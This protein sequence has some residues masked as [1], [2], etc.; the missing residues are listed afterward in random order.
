MKKLLAYICMITIL[1]STVVNA[2]EISY[3]DNTY[4][5]ETVNK[6][7]NIYIPAAYNTGEKK[8][9]E[10]TINGSKYVSLRELAKINNL[11]VK[12]N[13]RDKSIALSDIGDD[14]TYKLNGQMPVDKNYVFSPFC[15]KT[16]LAML[17]NGAKG[18]TKD[19]ILKAINVEN[20]DEYNKYV[21]ELNKKYAENEKINI[22]TASS[23]WVND[24]ILSEDINSVFADTV[25][26]C[27]N[28]VVEK[29]SMNEAGEKINNWISEATKG[30]FKSIA[31]PD[32]FD[33]ELINT[34]YFN[35]EWMN[36]FSTYG[37]YEDVFVNADG[38][39][40]RAEYMR[41]YQSDRKYYIDDN[42]TLVSLD[43]KDKNFSM[44]I[45]MTEDTG[46]DIDKYIGKMINDK[47]VNLCIP[48]FEIDNSIDLSNI[49]MRLG[50]KKAFMP[51]ADFTNMLDGRY[52]AVMSMLHGSKIKVAEWGTIA[53]AYTATATG[54]LDEPE[55]VDITI[56]RP[57]TYFVRDNESGE[58]LFMGRCNYLGV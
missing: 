31:L 50:I 42:T 55:T 28:G 22:N 5:L 53:A 2:T 44:Y 21:Q 48:K 18:E 57:F 12:W 43:Y 33:M 52:S 4:I 8:A 41:D 14:F 38:T 35:G 40:G 9:E 29:V 36:K 26:N 34:V 58:I 13:S 20:S 25:K 23:V 56:N 30:E 1:M 16:A 39:K 6:D 37:N 15:I 19:E 10:I 49:L 51:D 24:V 46:F 3:K 7:N 17:A 54:S 11:S 27:Y 47:K 32:K 45:A